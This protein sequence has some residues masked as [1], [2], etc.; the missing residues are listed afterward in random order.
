MSLL[1]NIII[2]ASV[3]SSAALAATTGPEKFAQLGH[4]LNTPTETRLASG[5]P[6]PDYWQQRADYRI[7]VTLDDKRQRLDGL[8]TIDYTNNSPHTL[9]YLWVQL[10]Q[11]RFQPDSDD[12]LTRTA[13]NFD[14]F[15]YGTMAHLLERQDFDGGFKIDAVTDANGQPLAHTINKTMMRIELPEPL[16]PA[17]QFTFSIDWDHNII[18][19]TTVSA[20]GGYEYFEADDN[21]LYEIAQWYPR[22]AAYTD[23]QGWQNKQFLGNGEFTLELGDF[24]VLITAPADHIVTA[25]GV[26]QNADEVLTAAQ[27]ERYQRAQT[28][29]EQLF[30]VTPA[31]AKQNEKSRS[32]DQKTWRFFAENVRD[33]AFASS[34]KFIW[35][36]QA[37]PNGGSGTVLAMS[38]YPNEAEP[39]WSQ[40]S[41]PAIAHTIEVYSRYTFEYPYPVSIS[42]NGPVGGM[43]YP[44]ITFN[45]PRPYPDQTYWDVRQVAGDKTWER[46]KYGLIS[47]I[48]HEVGHNYFPM[49]VNS[50]ERQWTWMDEGMN[51]FLQFVTEQEWEDGYPSRRGEPENIIEYMTSSPQVPIMTN[52]ETIHQFGNNAYGKPATAL[53]ILRESIMGRELFD[54]AFREFAQR[55][56]FKRPTPADFFRTMEDASAV[57]LDW[58]WRGWFYGTEHVDISIADV[59]L[60]QVDT[61][62]PDVE[63]AWQ[64]EEEERKEPTLSQ[65][66][67]ADVETLVDR[68]RDL[69]DFYTDY[70]EFDVTPYDYAQFEKLQ[71]SLTDK[72]RALLA[73][74][75]N[76]YTV[77]FD[78]VGGLVTPL[79]LRITYAGGKTEE[80]VIPAEIW[81]RNAQSVTKLFIADKQI[82]SIEFDPYRSTADANTA[83]NAWPRQPKASRFK[84][85]K[86]S[87]KPNPMRHQDKEQWEQPIR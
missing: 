45:K 78:N 14:K 34:R 57:D 76:F 63:K 66:R 87:E 59:S 19:A 22:I 39:L 55:W 54:Y 4:L 31:E 56:M 70:D 61:G 50:D 51:T 11:N 84:L 86:E 23:Y 20:R 82:T 77:R 81:R 71:Q 73:A 35:D 83:D 16:A 25:T 32:R 85:F 67:N 2:A 10:D 43:E 7:E 15:P 64:R 79:P 6:G 52:S 9:T 28:S 1:K 49:I 38:L 5:A 75:K 69:R 26:L 65:Q 44:M 21:Y 24:E 3:F 30:I 58:F 33:F 47:V 13:P 46:S 18:D 36:A 42:V 40:Y 53:N 37:V 29:S 48:I 12:M 8:V 17:A 62:N 74:D 41:T 68:N 27:L 72:E 60:Y 80:M